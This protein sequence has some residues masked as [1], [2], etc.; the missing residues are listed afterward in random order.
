VGDFALIATL[1]M[2]VTSR[3]I[4]PQYIVWLL[5]V[6]A[7]VVAFPRSTQRPV[8]VLLLVVTGLSQLG[9]P[10]LF[11]HLLHFGTS[12]IVVVT[13]RNVIMTAALIWG[14]VRLWQS[15]HAIV[16]ESSPSAPEPA[17]AG[18]R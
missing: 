14:F 16:E 1:A 9:F 15:T 2:V 18:E 3:V 5:G 17:R 13:L 6:G 12:A 11:S 4:S 7:C 8:V 10:V